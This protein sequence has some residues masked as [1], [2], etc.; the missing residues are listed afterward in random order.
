M[1][2]DG[3]TGALVPPGDV[4]AL[5]AALEPLMRQPERA[6]D[7]PSGAGRGHQAN[8]IDNE[9]ERIAGVY[10]VVWARR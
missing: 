10:A 8:S 5:V 3:A 9:A 1:I 6:A 7:G 2:A 4:D